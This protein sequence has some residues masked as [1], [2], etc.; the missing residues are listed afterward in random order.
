MVYCHLNVVNSCVDKLL[1]N[2]IEKKLMYS[3]IR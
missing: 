2:L 3:T 1:I